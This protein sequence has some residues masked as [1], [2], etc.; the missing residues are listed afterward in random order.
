MTYNMPSQLWNKKTGHFPWVE[1]ICPAN[2]NGCYRPCAIKSVTG[3]DC[4]LGKDT[5]QSSPNKPS[6]I[7]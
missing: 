6:G 5:S 2:G 1:G 7:F 4:P 3:K